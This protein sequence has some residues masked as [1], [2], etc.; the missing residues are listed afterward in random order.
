MFSCFN[1]GRM[2]DKKL[3]DI[4]VRDVGWVIGLYLVY[5]VVLGVIFALITTNSC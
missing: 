4:T 2:R 5:A 3:T 1:E